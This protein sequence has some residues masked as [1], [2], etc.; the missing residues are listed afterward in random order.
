MPDIIRDYINPLTY[1]V[2]KTLGKFVK[3]PN[4]ITVIGF[5]IGVLTGPLLYFG[6]VYISVLML[7]ISGAFDMLDG[8][9][10]RALNKVTKQ[11]AFL[12]SNLDRLVEASLY[13]GIAVY[14]PDLT[15]YS[16]LAFTFS[17]M[18][19]Y[20]R[21]RVEGLS[22]G[23]RPKS[24]EIGERGIRLLIMILAIIFGYIFY[25][26]IIVIIIALETFIERLVLYYKFLSAQ[27]T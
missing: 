26:L 2:G 15:I 25:G 10:A 7:I 6:F 5:I 9:V 22:N 17:I 23:I 13:A 20:S 24:L 12:D 21:A 19:S 4:T 16:F 18:V 27:N 14:K 1:R 8:A 3:N 11:G